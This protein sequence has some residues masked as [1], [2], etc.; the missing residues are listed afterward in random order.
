MNDCIFSH[1]DTYI[2]DEF[3]WK[4]P[5]QMTSCR[6]LGT[7]TIFADSNQNID[8]VPSKEGPGIQSHKFV[9]LKRVTH[10]KD[11]FWPWLVTCDCLIDQNM[12]YIFMAKRQN[13]INI[14]ICRSTTPGKHVSSLCRGHNNQDNSL[15]HHVIVF[16]PS[17]ESNTKNGKTVHIRKLRPSDKAALKYD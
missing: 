17:N 14:E 6:P 9:F 10:D 8:L 5:I 4:R 16:D 3:V 12:Q 2:V 15:D 1:E 7:G 11:S 13:K